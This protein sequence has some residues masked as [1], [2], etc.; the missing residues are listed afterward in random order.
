MFVSQGFRSSFERLFSLASKSITAC[1]VNNVNLLPVLEGKSYHFAFQSDPFVVGCGYGLAHL[2]DAPDTAQSQ[3]L[4]F[5]TCQR[6]SGYAKSLSPW[7][8]SATVL[9]FDQYLKR[10][11]IDVTD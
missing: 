7:L 11:E 9:P 4:I 8:Q 10:C 1:T 3:N 6:S 2:E 5:Q